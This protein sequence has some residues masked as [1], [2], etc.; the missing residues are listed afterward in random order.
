MGKKA[1]DLAMR[2]P[3]LAALMGVDGMSDFGAEVEDEDVLDFGGGDDFGVTFGDEMEGYGIPNLG[4]EHGIAFGAEAM[5]PISHPSHPLHHPNPAAQRIIA[6]HMK[7]NKH[8]DA[9]A[10]LLEP[11]QHSELKIERYTFSINDTI[12]ALGTSQAL[13]MSGAPDV[14]FRPQR[15]TMNT[16]SPGMVLVT[17][18]RVANVSFTVGG[19]LDSWQFN[20]N[21]VGQ[22]LDV[23][24]LTPANKA[25]VN[26]NYTGLVPMPLSGTGSYQF[27]VSFS[28]PATLSA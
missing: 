3:A 7:R 15:V 23:P 1:H 20:A 12:L 24:T 8:R 11:N 17:D 27:V 19:T 2:D 18:G 16:V 5:V 28:G 21:A 6:Q 26:A 10:H 9:R 25:T 4:D 14:N 13:T 22:S